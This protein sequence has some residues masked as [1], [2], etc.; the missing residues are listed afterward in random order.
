MTLHNAKGL[1]FP[2]VFLARHGT[3][4]VPAQPVDEFRGGAGR[5]AAALLC[6]HDARAE[7]ADPD[8]G[9]ST[10]GGSAAA[11]RSGPRRR[12]FLSEVPEHLIVNLGPQDDPGEVN[13]HGRA[14]RRAAIGA[15]QHVHRQNLQLARQHFAVLRR[16]RHAVQRRRKP[17]PPEPDS[18]RRSLRGPRPQLPTKPLPAAPPPVRRERAHRA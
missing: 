15:A 8:L 5:R 7:A 12:W 4:P 3:G 17:R 2:L 14:L 9:A 18:S 13:L 16:A 10:G 1:E 11:S 6:G